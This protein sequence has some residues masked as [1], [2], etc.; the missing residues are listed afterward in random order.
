MAAR[1]LFIGAD[2]LD[3]ELVLA[4][5]RAGHLPTFR[6]LLET[7]AWAF[8]TPPPGL[9]VGAVWPSF[10]TAT[11]PTRHGRYCHTQLVPGTYGTRRILASDVVGEPFW[12]TLSRAGRR[13][14]VVD[15]PKAPLTADL[16]GIQLA[17]W[18][19]H[20]PD[21]GSGFVTSPPALAAEVEARFGR[22]P[23]GS[24]D[25]WGRGAKDLAALRD[26]LVARVQQKTSLCQHLLSREAWDLFLAVFCEPQ[27]VG[28]Q[29]W[30]VHDTTHP[31]HD[32][33][34]RSAIGDPIKDVYIAID[35][36][37]GAL[38]ESVGPHTAVFIFASHGMVP[39][40]GGTFLLDAILRRLEGTR[41]RM[42]GARRRLASALHWCWS[43]AP[44]R[45]TRVA[46]ALGRQA[47]AALGTALPTL[48]QASGCRSFQI[49]NNHVYGAIRVNRV[50]REPHGRVRPG[51]DY[52]A[53]CEELTDDLLALVDVHSGVPVV[54][55]VLRTSDLYARSQWDDLPD[56]LVEWNPKVPVSSVYSPRT[57]IV[58]G[59]YLGQ[60]TG[61]HTPGGLLI[62]SGP[63]MSA[64]PVER[65][66]S[67][68]DVAPTIA[69][70]LGV[71][72]PDCDGEALLLQG[73][74]GP[75]PDD[76]TA[77]LG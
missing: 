50:G 8:S 16:N 36:G 30:H 29:F 59:A 26:A 11:S 45:R 73:H 62:A 48:A 61:D 67:T 55:R 60:R 1:V 18:G 15:V 13:V 43:R 25:R 56:L 53:Y 70:Q 14:A 52:E 66:V 2:A 27:C 4:W 49:P 51:A 63:S 12:Q 76:P 40:Y 34:V 19:T 68:A 64:G 5:A 20:D 32:P 24:C 21:R 46:A 23:V 39:H 44:L 75:R 17:D 28:H 9:Y 31:R 74:S 57:G 58:Y 37:I 71:T 35:T 22:D 33:A 6:R 77:S 69:A 41:V 42:G 38:L 10:Y 7:G 65:S 72:L 3:Q 54:Q 47:R